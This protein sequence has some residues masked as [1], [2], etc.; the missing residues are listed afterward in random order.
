[1]YRHELRFV[2]RFGV[3]AEF[4]DFAR[5]LADAERARGWTAPRVWQ[6]VSGQV[7]LIVIEHDYPTAERFREE[8]QAFH[9]DPGEV[10]HI[11][12][13][14]AA[15]AVPGTATQFDLDGFDL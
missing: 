13:G 6:S 10:G 3:R 12:G 15:L 9:T 7:N 5:R 8:R 14:L 2:L 4:E 1:M 11:L